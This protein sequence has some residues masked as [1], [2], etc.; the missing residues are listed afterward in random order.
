MRYQRVLK[1]LLCDMYSVHIV[2]KRYEKKH[3][4]NLEEEENLTHLGTSLG[5]LEEDFL[6]SDEEE[7][8]EGDTSRGQ[9]DKHAVDALMFG[10]F[11]TDEHSQDT[12][13]TRQQI[14]NEI[15]SSSKMH[16]VLLYLLYL[17][18]H[19]QRQRE[20]VRKWNERI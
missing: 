9:L 11:G 18:S 7:D 13:K 16:K 8:E 17:E 10:G 15:I 20:S 1:V 2:K 3:L 12:P 14:M 5:S 4:F 19:H 6:N